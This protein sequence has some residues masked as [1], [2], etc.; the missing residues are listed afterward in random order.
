MC[1][2]DSL[3]PG[4]YEFLTLK[5]EIEASAPLEQMEY[6]W[7]DPGADHKLQQG[8]SEDADDKQRSISCITVD[9]DGL[10]RFWSIFGPKPEGYLPNAPFTHCLLYTS[11]APA[12]VLEHWDILVGRQSSA[13][14]SLRSGDME[15]RAEDVQM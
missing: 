8:L 15:V 3:E 7:I 13:G 12:S 9:P 5:Q 2:R 14:F 10:E 1:I 4:D 11:H 6:H